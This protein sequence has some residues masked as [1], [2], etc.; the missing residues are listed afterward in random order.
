VPTGFPAAASGKRAKVANG[1]FEA[2]VVAE[3]HP[4]R[5][6]IRLP[7]LAGRRAHG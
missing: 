3:A 7:A 4:R 6:G 2:V 5:I 1:T